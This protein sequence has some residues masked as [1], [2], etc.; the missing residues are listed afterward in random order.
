MLTENWCQL[1]SPSFVFY[2]SQPLPAANIRHLDSGFSN[3]HLMHFLSAFAYS[4]LS[5]W[6]AFYPTPSPLGKFP[7]LIQFLCL[8]YSIFIYPASPTFLSPAGAKTVTH[9][10]LYSQYHICLAN[11]KY[12]VNVYWINSLYGM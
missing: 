2:P 5:L 11:S 7:P 8:C 10:S 3:S 1:T 9:S 6:K 4:I 12:E